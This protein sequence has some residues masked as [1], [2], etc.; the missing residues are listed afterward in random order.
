MGH[1]PGIHGR[2]LGAS[3]AAGE[4]RSIRSADGQRSRSVCFLLCRVSSSGSTVLGH[5]SLVPARFPP[6]RLRPGRF[7]GGFSPGLKSTQS[8]QVLVR[9][10]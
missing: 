6:G 2:V 10:H 8:N 5:W 4:A 3:P 9:D 1:S 7:A